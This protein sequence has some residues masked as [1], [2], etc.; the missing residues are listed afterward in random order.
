M[1]MARKIGRRRCSM[2]CCMNRPPSRPVARAV[3]SRNPAMR[4][5]APTQ[6]MPARMWIR[7]RI[8]VMIDSLAV[9]VVVT[10]PGHTVGGTG[11]IAALG[12][13]VEKPVGAHHDL[14]SPA[15]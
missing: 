12:Y 13:Q 14:D 1:A 15:V 8:S 6:K 4:K 7:R 5:T 11:L 9:L 2:R 3:G 10:H